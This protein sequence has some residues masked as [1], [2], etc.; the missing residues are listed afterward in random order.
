MALAFSAIPTGTVTVIQLAGR[1]NT[2]TVAEFDRKFTA[3][4]ATL[5]VLDFAELEY[6]SSAGLRSILSAFK[7]VKAAGGDLVVAAA[8]PAVVEAFDISGFRALIPMHPDRAAAV[9]ALA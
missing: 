5:V 6:V 1:L 7:R 9:A 8:K 4:G 3:S 2:A